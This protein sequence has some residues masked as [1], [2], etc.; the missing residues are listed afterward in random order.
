MG[1]FVGGGR[2]WIHLTSKKNAS[3]PAQNIVQ[4]RAKSTTLLFLVT[5]ERHI[6]QKR[7]PARKIR[8]NPNTYTTIRREKEEKRTAVKTG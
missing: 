4:A 5:C 1:I 3:T 6:R 8:A 2:P 7:A